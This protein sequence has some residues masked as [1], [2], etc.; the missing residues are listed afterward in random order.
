MNAEATQRQATAG[1]LYAVAAYTINGPKW[2]IRAPYVAREAM[3]AAL[4]NTSP[5]RP[6][7]D[8]LLVKKKTKTR[9]AAR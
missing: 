6:T 4:L 2:R 5:Y 1:L 9:S 8:P 3:R 7:Q